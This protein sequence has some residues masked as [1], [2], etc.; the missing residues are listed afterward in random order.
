MVQGEWPPID[1]VAAECI[2]EE[3]GHYYK[4]E[5]GEDKLICY[6]CHE[7][8]EANRPKKR[9]RNARNDGS[10]QSASARPNEW[11]KRDDNRYLTKEWYAKYPNH[12]RCSQCNLYLRPR[13]MKLP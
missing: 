9:A 2:V 5:N 6:V 1:E 4:R 7:E 8:N 10:R 13:E 11:K 3:V 12:Q